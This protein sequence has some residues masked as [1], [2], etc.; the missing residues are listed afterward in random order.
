MSPSGGTVVWTSS[1]SSSATT[2]SSASAARSRT[3][4]EV[5]PAG[6]ATL[7]TRIFSDP[8]LRNVVGSSGTMNSEPTNSSSAPN[9]APS[10]VHRLRSV[11]RIVGS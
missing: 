4:S 7:T 5:A 10:A 6:G 1:T 3:A 2:R 11:A 8:E 9:T